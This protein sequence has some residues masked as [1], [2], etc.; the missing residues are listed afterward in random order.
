ME[1]AYDHFFRKATNGQKPHTWQKTI[2]QESHCNNRLI[3]I[4]TGFGKTLGVIG[5]WLWN[6]VEKSNDE[7]PRRLVWCLPMRVLVEQTESEVKRILEAFGLLWDGIGDHRGQIGV[8]LLMGGSDA[9]SWHLYPEENA[10]L[11]G[12]QDMLLSRAMNRG[13]AAP[14]ARWPMEFGLLNI[15]SLWVLDEV[16]LMDVGL[17]TATQLQAFREKDH[18]KRRIEKRSYTWWMSATLQKDWLEKSPDTKALTADLPATVIPPKQRKG[19]LWDDV[20]KACTLVSFKSENE[21]AKR[22][23]EDHISG[24]CGADGP[25]LVVLNSVKRAVN[26][27]GLLDKDKSLQKNQVDIKL[28]HSRFRPMERKNWCEDFLNREASSPRTNR[29]IVATQ[30]VE[31]GVDMSAALLFTDLA[32][33]SSLVQRFGRCA[34]WGGNASVIVMNVPTKDDRAAAPY[35]KSELDAARE[36]IQRLNDVSPLSLEKFEE[37]NTEILSALY[38][39][40]PQ[41]LL[42]RHE[43]DELFDTSPDLSGADIDISRFIRSGEERDLSVFWENIPKKAQPDP[44]RRPL[45]D[46]LCSIPFLQAREWLCGKETKESRKPRLEKGNRAWIFDYVEGEWRT[47]ERKDLYPGQIVLVAADCGGYSP[48][49]GWDPSSKTTVSR[50]AYLKTEQTDEADASEQSEALSISEWKT[51]ATHN[52]ETAHQA[53]EIAK[54]LVPSL[55]KHFELAGNWHDVGKV[56]PAFQGSIQKGLMGRPD[57]I[58]LAKAPQDAW[59]KGKRMYPMPD[60]TR[61][62]GFRH[63]LASTLA[64]FDVVHRRKPEHQALIGPYLELLRATRQLRTDSYLPAEQEPAS[65]PEREILE[66]SANEF[67]LITY[68]VCSHHGKVRVSW[69]VT[70][71]DLSSGAST[72]RIHGI[73]SGDTLPEFALR[74]TDGKLHQLPSYSLDLA[75]SAI[76][77]NP[78]TGRG[79][80]E[81]VLGLLDRMGPFTLAWL[82]ALFRAADIRASQQQTKDPLL[83]NHH[84]EEELERDRRTLEAPAPRGAVEDT[85]RPHSPTGGPQHGLR[86]RTGGRED[87]GSRTEAAHHTTRRLNTTLGNITYHELAPHLSRRVQAIEADIAVGRYSGRAIDESLI[88]DLHYRICGDLTPDFAGRWR[89]IDVMVGNHEPPGYALI[90]SLMKDYILDLQTRLKI[91]GNGL[92]DL[93]LELLAFAEGRL[94][95][96]HPFADFN[97]R[98][99]RVFL[100]HL[101]RELDLPYIDPTPN[102]GN[103]T[104][105][106]FTALRAAD[107][108][109]WEPLIQTWVLRFEKEGE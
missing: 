11:I 40:N 31:A 87:A 4:P 81:R 82:E 14:R 99:T 91:A 109:N 103:E 71:A 46:E 73:E 24:G 35:L 98:T 65:L 101:L 21:I 69:H 83:E 63:E 6:R 58:D 105:N 70:T 48:Q 79:W 100:S 57:R 80:T 85:P 102:H 56:F 107:Q 92:D 45:R 16:Q 49:T 72:Y 34:R 22:I 18:S 55:K 25:T 36:V 30:V 50:P 88:L 9:G 39:F 90:P 5:A 74:G 108:L 19:P 89:S 61:R 32:P 52:N 37:E 75:P 93:T 13:Y 44:K 3:R 38:P 62:P 78:K 12:T 8:H 104:A 84:V 67:D 64:L 1:E 27:F 47:A 33:W 10:I 7:W 41:H 77:L 106:Y 68:L 15:D 59:H 60:G 20:H 95:S 23:A 76:G 53:G 43:I 96:I 66:L 42:L 54:A 29:I 26:I 51:I 86:G 97:G 2:G 28:V 17:A 94:L